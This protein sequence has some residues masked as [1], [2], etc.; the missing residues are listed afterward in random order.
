VNKEIKKS[1]LLSRWKNKEKKET[2][3]S[4]ITKAPFSDSYPLTNAQ[5]RLWFL[6]NLYPENVFYNLSEYY[7]FINPNW[8]KAILEK[9]TIWRYSYFKFTLRL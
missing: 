3:K 2:P 7:V 8:N 6:Q 5:H 9:Q 4:V 1:S